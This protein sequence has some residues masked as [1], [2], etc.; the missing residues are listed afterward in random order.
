MGCGS[1]K[2]AAANGTPLAAAT[3]TADANTKHAAEAAKAA[4]AAEAI[5]NESAA[6][7][8]KV[9]QDA[10]QNAEIALAQAQESAAA[11]AAAAAAQAEQAA[12]GA[13]EVE[14]EYD[15]ALAI[16]LSTVLGLKEQSPDVSRYVSALRLEGKT[17]CPLSSIFQYNCAVA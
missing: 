11:I 12:A 5:M 17:C 9:I 1:S 2:D 8:L 16:H 10:K 13:K 7:S 14:D 6:A 4:E 3:S 15:S